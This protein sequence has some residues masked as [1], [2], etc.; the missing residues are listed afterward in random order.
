MPAADCT[1]SL[2]TAPQAADGDIAR[3]EVRLPIP[4]AEALSGLSDLEALYRLN[5][6]LE[7]ISW[8]PVAGGFRLVAR[9]ELN[10]RQVDSTARVAREEGDQSLRLHLAW[11]SGLRQATEMSLTADGDGVR[12]AVI[13]H[14]PRVDDPADPRVLEVD[15][16]LVPWVAAM[17]RHWLA[18]QRWGWV[19]GWRWWNERLLPGLSPRARRMVRLLVW[20]SL[21]EFTVFLVVVVAWRAL[22]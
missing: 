7:V 18:R 17:R 12:L 8:R 21:I 13:D 19:P 2:T 10:E 20:I 4:F 1:A 22:G 5:P 9:N 11:S 15:R 6:H 14:Y 16:S 3:A